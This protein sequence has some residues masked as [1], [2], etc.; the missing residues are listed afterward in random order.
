MSDFEEQDLLNDLAKLRAFCAGV[1]AQLDSYVEEIEEASTVIT[2]D[3]TPTV[4]FITAHIDK[5]SHTRSNVFRLNW[6]ATRV[7]SDAKDNHDD[8]MRPLLASGASNKSSFEERH[9]AYISRNIES[10][11]VLRQL[12]KLVEVD[13][14]PFM[15]YLDRKIRW[16]EDKRRQLKREDD[17]FRYSSS[18]DY[19]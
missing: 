9:A 2:N 15:F 14:R 18:K 7:H 10:Y 17:D 6:K 4:P 8:G 16:L 19:Q 12:E 13:L 3:A 1:K 5:W 11:R